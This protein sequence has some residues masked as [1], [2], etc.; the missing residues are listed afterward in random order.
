MAL[1]TPDGIFAECGARPFCAVADTSSPLVGRAMKRLRGSLFNGGVLVLRPDAA[2][3][4]R[5]L[6][7]AREDALRPRARWFAEQGFL[8][9]AFSNWT[10]LPPGYNR[11]G[12]W[13]ERKKNRS[14]WRADPERDVFVHE[15]LWRL[16]P[17]QRSAFGLE[18]VALPPRRIAWAL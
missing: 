10:R 18:G 14:E 6:C 9:A 7:G 3:H 17:V 12:A 15:K 11:Q 16:S 13:F 5:L 8:N 2:T 4:A 1:R